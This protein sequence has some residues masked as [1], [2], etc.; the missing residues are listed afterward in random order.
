MHVVVYLPSAFYS[1]IASTVVE[2]LQAVNDVHGSPLFSFEFVAKRSRAVSK[3][4]IS[5]PA[6]IRPS[7]GWTC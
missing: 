2:T 3:S 6:K 7:K 5:F 4:G 1:A